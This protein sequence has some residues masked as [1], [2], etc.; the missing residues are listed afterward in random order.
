MSLMYSK[1]M[2]IK[3]L[4]LRITFRVGPFFHLLFL[5][6]FPD[7]G[8]PMDKPVHPELKYIKRRTEED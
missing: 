2:K 7:N 1:N 6:F 5:L 4:K 8:K 3:I